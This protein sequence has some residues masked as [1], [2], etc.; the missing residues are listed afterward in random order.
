MRY[1][2]V[3]E[4]QIIQDWASTV[5]PAKIEDSY[6]VSWLSRMLE[7]MLINQ[8]GTNGINEASIVNPYSTQTN[9]LGIGGIN[10]APA[11]SGLNAFFNGGSGSPDRYPNVF[12]LSVQ[13]AQKTIGF[14]LVNV[15]PMSTPAGQVAY[16]E[17]YYADGD[18]NTVNRPSL[19]KINAPGTY[20]SGTAYYA[21]NNDTLTVVTGDK[22]LQLFFAG[23]SAIDGFPIF[24]VGQVALEATVGV[25]PVTTFAATTNLKVADVFDGNG[26]IVGAVPNGSTPDVTGATTV[27][28]ST[29]A[30]TTLA[31]LVAAIEDHIQ[32]YT[33]SGRSDTDRY[34]GNFL[35]R[36]TRLTTG[37]SRGV[38]EKTY[39][40]NMSIEV[41]TKFIDT[42][43]R[44]LTASLTRQQIFDL[45]KVQ[46]IEAAPM[47]ENLLADQLSQSISKEITELAFAMGWTSAKAVE[48]SQNG[49]SLNV[50]L[51]PALNTSTTVTY[52]GQD[53]SQL[54][55]NVPAF[56]SYGG[57][58]NLQSM[59]R[60]ISSKV[61]M[62]SNV[63]TQRN[64]GR[65]GATFI[66]TNMQLATAMQDASQY[67]LAAM[68]NNLSQNSGSLFSIGT[69]AGMTIYVDPYMSA[70]DNR[71]LV[72]RR[73][74]DVEPGIKF[75]P[76]AMAESVSIIPEGTMG[77]KTLLSSRYA[78][79]PLG[80]N[81]E[82]QYITLH[83]RLGNNVII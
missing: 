10:P 81:P 51:D 82:V 14:D 39:P 56:V 8:V 29:G 71:I 57:L 22:F 55:C 38:A 67:N 28:A 33:G 61:L 17:F 36:G 43:E 60:R 41:H 32:G 45:Q 35:D 13:I 26:R 68:N 78:L 65:G 19:I 77:Y 64:R 25:G 3:N 6:K 47:M 73:G 62:A 20:T 21:T 11:P 5:A 24:E 70:N 66:V 74:Q 54:T 63:I 76:Y 50:T 79:V 52:V 72:G 46:G 2:H 75:M 7:N 40:R 23:N 59:Q 15:I 27:A 80:I 69:L 30:V 58:E 34:V 83:V 9:T 42:V 48:V 12:A 4:S 16:A 18:V 44:Q 1:N 53:G 49:F 31:S 37:L